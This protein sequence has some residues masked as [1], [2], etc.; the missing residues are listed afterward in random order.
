MGLGFRVRILT[1]GIVASPPV[2]KQPK[3]KHPQSSAAN[4]RV[5]SL[6]T[7]NSGQFL[8][9]RRHYSLSDPLILSLPFLTQ[10]QRNRKRETRRKTYIIANPNY[11]AH[12]HAHRA[13]N[14]PC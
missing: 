11:T 13:H 2:C 1:E 14:V 8:R 9:H 3:F 4:I 5:H 12:C 6:A 10:K 7:K